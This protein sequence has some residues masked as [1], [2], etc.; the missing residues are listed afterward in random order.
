MALPQAPVVSSVRFS[1]QIFVLSSDE[2]VEIVCSLGE[3][4]LEY[5]GPFV[6]RNI[7]GKFLKQLNDEDITRTLKELK[8]LDQ[9][10]ATTLAFLLKS[11]KQ[12][13]VPVTDTNHPS[14]DNLEQ[15]DVLFRV[16]NT[17]F[18]QGKLEDAKTCY[19]RTMVGYERIHGS[20]HPSHL[21]VVNNLGTLLTAMEAY[22]EAQ[23]MFEK[24]LAGREVTF[25]MVH[26]RTLNTCHHLGEMLKKCAKRREAMEYFIRCYSGYNDL[27]GG[28]H[29]DTIGC[30]KEVEGLSREMGH[31]G[32]KLRRE[33]KMVR[34]ILS[35]V[36][37]VLWS[38]HC[39]SMCQ[40]GNQ[41]MCDY[42]STG[43]SLA[44][45]VAGISVVVTAFYVPLPLLPC[46]SIETHSSQLCLI[47]TF[48]PSHPPRP[49]LRPNSRAPW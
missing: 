3:A 28:A 19:Q 42:L 24:A 11:L 4:F 33:G 1:S 15:C 25:G 44:P 34:M 16:G 2:L 30:R 21:G 49:K 38:G 37:F 22:P 18:Q 32:L 29:N 40:S 45:D 41:A 6:Q 12:L 47:L 31:L 20:T 9:H 39:P 48:P 10:H 26:I 7:D 17:L 27:L 8:V 43:S 14:D 13:A 35:C 5:E 36:F 23:L 46:L